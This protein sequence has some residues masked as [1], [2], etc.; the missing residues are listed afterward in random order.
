ML[1]GKKGQ[2]IDGEITTDDESD[3]RFYIEHGWPEFCEDNEFEVGDHI[4]F[5]F[6]SLSYSRMANVYKIT[7]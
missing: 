2:K 3:P 4:R 5:K 7:M 1:S 6:A